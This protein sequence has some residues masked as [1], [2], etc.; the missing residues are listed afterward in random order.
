MD[1]TFSIFICVKCFWNETLD[2]TTKKDF[3][4]QNQVKK[5]CV[6]L[7]YFNLLESYFRFFDLKI[8]ILTLK[9]KLNH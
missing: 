5:Q 9:I 8:D 7:C 3:S 4:S 6:T 2:Q 1:Y